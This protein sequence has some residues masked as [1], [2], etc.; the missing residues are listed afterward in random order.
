MSQKV[1]LSLDAMGGA[2]APASVIE[3]ASI[4]LKYHPDLYY[5]FYGNDQLLN[6]GIS[7]FPNLEGNCEIFPTKVVISDEEQPIKALRAGAQSSMRKAID[8]V[9]DG[10][11]SACVSAGNTGAL[12]VMSKLVLKEISGIKRPAIV[13]VM[14]TQTGDGTVMLDLGANAECDENNLFQFALMGD[15]FAK[16]AL[17]KQNPSIALLNVGVEQ[18]KGRDV[19]KKTYDMLKRSSLN[20]VGFIEGH[21]LT[22]GEVDVVVTDGFSGN[23]ALKTAEGTVRFVMDLMKEGLTSNPIAKVGGLLAKKSIKK[24]LSG[25]DPNKKNGAMFIGINGV[26]VKSHGSAS[27]EG[28]AHAISVAH[29]LVKRDVNK[30]IVKEL[31]LMKGISSKANIVDIIKEKSAKILGLK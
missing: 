19:E 17:G 11:A 10:F 7:S 30:Q 8:A 14:P 25:I 1:I 6:D 16:A 4:A 31:D 28:F 29:D 15:C 3:G 18:I 20:F 21:D 13:G 24:A 12:M 27:A 2:G 9:K 22:K 5:L 26:V 23:I